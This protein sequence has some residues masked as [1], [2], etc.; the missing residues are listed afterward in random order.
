MAD[1]PPTAELSIEPAIIAVDEPCIVTVSGSSP[2]GLY[3]VWWGE[4][5]P[6]L[7]PGTVD[8]ADAYLNI[9][10]DWGEGRGKLSHT[11]SR[12]VTFKQPGSYSIKARSRDL[13]Y[14][15]RGEQHQSSIP[16]VRVDVIEKKPE[17]LSSITEFTTD[18]EIASEGESV[19]FSFTLRNE[20]NVPGDIFG[21]ITDVNTGEGILDISWYNVPVGDEVSF[22]TSRN[23]PKGDWIVRLEAG[24]TETQE[25]AVRK[26]VDSTRELMIILLRGFASIV[27]F[28]SDPMKAFPG[29]PVTLSFSI[30]N[31]GDATDTLFG[32]IIDIDTGE[33]IA[34]NVWDSVAIG[35]TVSFAVQKTMPG[36]G[37]RLL[38]EA[39]HEEI[40]FVVDNI[41]EIN[42][43][44]AEK[45]SLWGILPAGIL[46]ASIVGVMVSKK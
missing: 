38:L 4:W 20:G 17:A 10:Q 7:I 19:T 25:L 22:S 40:E 31:D 33:E 41:M 14:P 43:G 5:G 39:G 11:Y 3:S 27:D 13:S 15:I 18:K 26:I 24:H 6:R 30:R 42:I 45:R 21:R 16:S 2:L 34:L 12:I 23:M 36:K 29:E 46:A 28:T 37:W 32:R 8:G 35:Q 1:F 44:E 9:A